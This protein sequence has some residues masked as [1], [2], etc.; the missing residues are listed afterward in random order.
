MEPNYSSYEVKTF[1]EWTPFDVKVNES[2]ELT[3]LL[4]EAEK[5]QEM[6]FDEKL[7]AIK[8]IALK[9]MQNAYEIKQ[10]LNAPPAFAFT[11]VL[12]V[13]TPKSLEYALKNKAGCCRYQSTLFFLLGA[14]AKLGDKHYLQSTSI[15]SKLNTCYNDV[16][17]NGKVHHI[18]IFTESLQNKKY[19]YSA[20]L[21]QKVF[22]NPIAADASTSFLAYTVDSNQT[23]R[24]Y[25][26]QGC[27]FDYIPSQPS[28]ATQTDSTKL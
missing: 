19:D 16:V 1:N 3:T 23:V 5:C 20:H 12:I 13:D 28:S 14:A 25:A 18:S 10:T 27:H 6:P 9:A 8:S 11:C 24:Q 21:G 2:E 7:A 26:R 22:E 4:A 15:H 17:Y